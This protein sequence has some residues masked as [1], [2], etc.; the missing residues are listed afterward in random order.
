MSGQENTLIEM[1]ADQN[2]ALGRIEGIVESMKSDLLGNG[3]PGRMTKAEERLTQLEEKK[4]HAMGWI[5]GAA[6]VS[7]FLTGS[8]LTLLNWLH[9]IPKVKQ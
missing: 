4:T 9:I 3:Q 2:K 5:A 7:A 6:A 1:M 8:F